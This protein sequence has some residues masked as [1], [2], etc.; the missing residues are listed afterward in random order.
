[1]ISAHNDNGVRNIFNEEEKKASRRKDTGWDASIT[2]EA[3][4]VMPVVLST[5]FALI[6]LTLQLHDICRIQGILDKTLHQAGMSYKHRTELASDEINYAWI[7]DRGVFYDLFRDQSGEEEEV[8]RYLQQKF[9]KGLFLLKITKLEA[10]VKKTKLRVKIEAE[11]I[12]SLPWIAS[13]FDGFSSTVIAGDYP[14]HN[15]AETIR[16]CEIILDTGSQVKGVELLKSK[17]E[18]FL[19]R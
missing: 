11:T 7:G 19:K 8:K 1:M 3:A 13:L 12:I 6:Y 2:V 16:I 18:G 10:E 5:V 4:F 9:S 17:L 14:V 15:P